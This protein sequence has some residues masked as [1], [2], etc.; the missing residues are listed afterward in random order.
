MICFLTKLDAHT[1]SKLWFKHIESNFYNNDDDDG[2]IK[3]KLSFCH[4]TLDYKIFIFI[5]TDFAHFLIVLTIK[6]NLLKGNFET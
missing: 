3:M 2:V 6:Q 1:L 5:S 4:S